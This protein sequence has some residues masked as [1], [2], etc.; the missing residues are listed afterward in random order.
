V[1]RHAAE[2]LRA[3]DHDA[4]AALYASAADDIGGAA[5]VAPDP[6]VRDEMSGEEQLLRSLSLRAIEDDPSRVAKFTQMD[7]HRKARKRGRPDSG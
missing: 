5:A 1:K 3:G 7:A 4:A 6:V 2:A